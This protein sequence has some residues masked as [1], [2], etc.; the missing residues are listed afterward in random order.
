M[1]AGVFRGVRHVPI[2]DVADPRP[3]AADIV[4]DVKACGICGSDLHTY[5][6]AQLAQEGQVMGHEFAG[7]VVEVGAAVVG[8]AVGDRV[9]GLPIQPCGACRRCREGS[10]HLC[11][12]WTQRSIGYGLPGGFAERLRIPDAVLDDNVHRLPDEL[13]FEDGALVEPLAVAVHAVGRTQPAPD[14]VAVVLGLG[15]IGLQVAQVLLARGVARVIGADLSPLRRSVA[16]RL[17]VTAVAGD[18]DVGAAIAA[19]AG[20][21]EVDVVFEATGAPQLVQSAMELVRAGGTVIVIALYERRAD[22]EPT[23]MVQKELTVRGSAIYT[24][25]EFHEAIELLASGRAQAQPLITQRHALEDLG[26]AFEAQLDKDAAIKVMVS[27]TAAP[28]RDAVASG[29][30]VAT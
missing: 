12:V 27:P 8:I 26:A 16:E 14:D 6:A 18:G 24:P 20:G 9:T 5:V 29:Q 19:A 1:R 23:L 7:E 17:G 10:G 2:E 3:G 21:R 15:T 22:I 11:E 25:A 13:T 30:R 4:L 28:E